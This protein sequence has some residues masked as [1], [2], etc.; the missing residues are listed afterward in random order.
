MLRLNLQSKKPLTPKIRLIK[1]SQ[2]FFQQKLKKPIKNQKINSLMEVISL[3]AR[4]VKI[5]GIIL[6]IRKKITLQVD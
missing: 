4:N 6:L 2:I 1:L 3:F 5:R